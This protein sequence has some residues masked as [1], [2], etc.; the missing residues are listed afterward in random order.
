MSTPNLPP[1]IVSG[2]FPEMRVVASV[3]GERNKQS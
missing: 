2:Y 3:I 1:N